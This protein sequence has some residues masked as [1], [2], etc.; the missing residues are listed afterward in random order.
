MTR[1]GSAS[2]TTLTHAF[3]VRDLREQDETTRV[4]KSKIVILNNEW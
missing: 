4:R 3:R 1:I 2:S